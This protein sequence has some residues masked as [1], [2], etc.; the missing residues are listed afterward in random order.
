MTDEIETLSAPVACPSTTEIHVSIHQIPDEQND[1]P[2][3]F[4]PIVAEGLPKMHELPEFESDHLDTMMRIAARI[5]EG[6]EKSRT[7]GASR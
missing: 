3:R 7:P 6:Q 2:S 4:G 1:C 5:L